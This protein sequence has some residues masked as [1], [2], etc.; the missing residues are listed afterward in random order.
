LFVTHSVQ[1]IPD[2]IGLFQGAKVEEVGPAPVRVHSFDG[3]RS[4]SVQQ[5]QV[6][7]VL[8]NKLSLALVSRLLLLSWP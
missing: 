2:V 7:A 1:L 8:V 3:K 6:V 5:G 4:E